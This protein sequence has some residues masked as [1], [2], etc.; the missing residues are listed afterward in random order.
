[1]AQIT[2]QG[3][4]FEHGG[5][6][7][8][9][10]G[11]HS[12][13]GPQSIGGARIQQQQ[14]VGNFT[15]A[16]LWEAPVWD[17][18]GSKYA[19]GEGRPMAVEPMA[20][21]RRDGRFDLSQPNPELYRRLRQFVVV[22]NRAGRICNVILFEGTQ[23]AY[24]N[25]WHGHPFRSGNN[26]QGIRLDRPER[27]HQL[28][29]HNRYQR[30]HVDRVIAAVEGLQVVLEVGNELRPSSH[31]W[32]RAMVRHIQAQT[33]IPVGVSFTPG[34]GD[35]WMATTG[36]DWWSPGWHEGPV[37]GA[38]VPQVLN[39]DH[40]IALRNDPAGVER[41]HRAGHSVLVMDALS[42]TV[43]KNF[44]S[45]QPTRDVITGLVRRL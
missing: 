15:A 33:R 30:E 5:E 14:L 28:G 41:Y 23:P 11:S 3:A 4:W 20:W 40:G 32:Q 36:A 24:A 22:S 2:T 10:I 35:G 42:E 1:M 13:H 19:G 6:R 21:Q 29:R 16:W 37:T 9:L 7:L 45:L 17:T 25:S 44:G 27:V 39:T 18:T 43:L 8:R 26:H 31:A 34:A 12:W 38:R